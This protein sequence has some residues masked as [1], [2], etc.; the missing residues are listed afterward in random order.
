MITTVTLNPCMDLTVQVPALVP[1]GLNLVTATRTDIAGKGVNV[2][3][4]LRALGYATICTGINYDGNGAQLDDFLEMNS[5]CRRFAVA[6]GNIRTNIKVYDGK[7]GEMTEINHRGV[8]VEPAV[9]EQ[10]LH[11]LLDC[12]ARSGIVV[13]SGRIPAGADDAIYRRSMAAVK[14][15][16]REIKMI[17]DAEGAPLREALRQKPYLIKP[18]VYELETAFRCKIASKADAVAACRRVIEKGVA[19]VCLSMGGEGAMIVDREAAFYA[20][21]MEVEVRGLQGAGDSMVA[22]LCKGIKD[23]AGIGDMLRYGVA[24]A[25]A[26]LLREG[27]LLCRKADFDRLLPKVRLERLDVPALPPPAQPKSREKTAGEKLG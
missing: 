12:A 27:T 3:I 20:P 24:A 11:E 1:G 14:K 4:V 21:A 6:H 15:L 19:V 16:R 17:V 25:S 18:N 8:P 22:G 9:L 2:S 13:F 23:G 5:I 7:T 10:Y 26:S